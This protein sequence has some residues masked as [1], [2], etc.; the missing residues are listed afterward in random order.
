MQFAT[1]E[2]ERR[3]KSCVNEN[4]PAAEALNDERVQLLNRFLDL[5][6]ED[7]YEG[8]R[9]KWEAAT[10]PPP[11]PPV[12]R[13]K[14][15]LSNEDWERVNQGHR[16]TREN[17][18]ALKHQK[19]PNYWES[20]QG[21]AFLASGENCATQAMVDLPPQSSVDGGD[22]TTASE[23]GTEDLAEELVMSAIKSGFQMMNSKSDE[24]T[25]ETICS[26]DVRAIS[27]E[28]SQLNQHQLVTAHP[29]HRLEFSPDCANFG[30]VEEDATYRM[31]VSLK[32]TGMFTGEFKG[33]YKLVFI[34]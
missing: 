3:S 7:D 14:P 30:I 9:Q 27:R 29:R 17:L 5:A 26:H 6:K 19:V 13:A 10:A 21:A 8:L 23:C 16:E 18:A 32:N 2:K 20:A 25:E 12:E 31:R 28:L 34:N 22:C 1:E 33:D 11:P 15:K 4:S 24:K